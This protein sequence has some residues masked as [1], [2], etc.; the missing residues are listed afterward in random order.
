MPFYFIAIGRLKI[1]CNTK[2]CMCVCVC[3]LVLANYMAFYECDGWLDGVFEFTE[4]ISPCSN[5]NQITVDIKSYSSSRKL[6]VCAAVYFT[7]RK[8][9]SRRN[10]D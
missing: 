6:E 2:K 10:G 5:E 1:T 3:Y 9:R 8:P 7:T 4:W